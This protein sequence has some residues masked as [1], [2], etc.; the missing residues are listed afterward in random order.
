MGIAQKYIKENNC[1]NFW[2]GEGRLRSELIRELGNFHEKD[3]L[4][5]YYSKMLQRKDN[6]KNSP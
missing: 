2:T 6:I 3:F 5:N 1:P 4:K